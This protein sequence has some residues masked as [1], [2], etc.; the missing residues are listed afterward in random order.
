MAVLRD[1]G[2]RA[3]PKIYA[4]LRELEGTAVGSYRSDLVR[5]VANIRQDV[6][7]EHTGT[8]VVWE[9]AAALEPT[10]AEMLDVLGL[11]IVSEPDVEQQRS[12]VVT[13][14]GLDF[15]TLVSLTCATFP[16]L[17][18]E[19]Q[20]WLLVSFDPVRLAWT[21]F[22][23]NAKP[24]EPSAW[25]WRDATNEE[26]AANQQSMRA[27]SSCVP[28]LLVSELERSGSVIYDDPR[29]A[30]FRVHRLVQ[31]LAA[32][33][34]L[35]PALIGQDDPGSWMVDVQRVLAKRLADDPRIGAWATRMRESFDGSTTAGLER[36]T[37]T[38]TDDRSTAVVAQE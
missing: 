19:A 21:D 35:E 38:N 37:T 36:L 9:I 22:D 15:N 16:L 3:L 28:P 29:D 25:P 14:Y 4:E 17:A 20:D 32:F 13:M 23:T 30:D 7:A 26:I 1:I 8:S 31:T 2:P 6:V 12:M 18:P 27:A 10:D 24:A 33:D 34:E 5:V 11:V